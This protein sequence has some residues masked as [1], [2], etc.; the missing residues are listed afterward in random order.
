MWLPRESPCR[1]SASR[2]CPSETCSSRVN[3]LANPRPEPPGLPSA[4]VPSERLADLETA[5]EAPESESARTRLPPSSASTFPS[6]T[7]RLEDRQLQT[8]SAI[9]PP[10]PPKLQRPGSFRPATAEL[11]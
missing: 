10:C 1:T 6:A 3:D 8:G 2:E 4:Q 9:W 5:P 11:T 7:F